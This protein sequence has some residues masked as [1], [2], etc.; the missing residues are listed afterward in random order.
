MEQCLRLVSSKMID[1]NKNRTR[2]S[3]FTL[4]ELLVTMGV[5]GVIVSMAAPSFS[6]FAARQTIKA[7]VQRFS[8]ILI[9]ARSLAMTTK[10][11]SAVVCWNGNASDQTVEGVAVPAKTIVA[12]SGSRGALGTLEATQA[13]A[14]DQ[15]VYRANEADGCIGFDSQGRLNDNTT[16]APISFLVCRAAGDATDAQRIEVSI[17][18]RV[19]ARPNTSTRGANVQS[20]A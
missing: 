11:A 18:G 6:D 17:T 10:S 12:Y 5:L 19:I 7:D 8:K 2:S 15:S 14:E 1:T 9:A 20:C 16:A 4:L 3:G 13:F